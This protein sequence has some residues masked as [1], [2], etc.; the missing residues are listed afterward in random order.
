MKLLSALCALV[1]LTGQAVAGEPVWRIAT[2][3]SYR[4]LSQLDDRDTAEWMRDFDQYILSVSDLLRMDVRQLPP[5]TVIVF[6]R[7]KDYTPYKLM[8]PNGTT[9]NVG[10]QFVWH[11]TWSMI[12]MAYDAQDDQSRRAI[13]HE[14]TH[15][16]MSI[17][18]SAQP[19]W[20]SEGIAEL[21]STFE[22]HGDKVAW[23][24]PIAE[25]LT[26]LRDSGLMPLETFL[27]QPSA[28]FDRDDHTDE[29]YA[30]A[31]AF[32]HF[33][34]FSDNYSRRPLMIKFLQTYRTESGEAT[35]KAV[36]GQSLPDTEHAF[37]VYVN[38]RRWTYVTQPVKVAADPP[39]LQSAPP[40][41]V[42]A[43][44]GFLALGAG[45]PEL[46][47]QHADKSVELDGAAP[48]SHALLAYLAQ[49]GSHTELAA[50]EADAALQ[51]G[52]RDSGLYTLLGDSYVEGTNS[53][54]PD[55]QRTRVSMYEN[56]INLSPWRVDA[57]DRLSEALLSLETP[58]LEDAKF[59]GVGIRAFPGDDWLRVGNAV[60]TERLGQRA[61]AMQAIEAVLRPD[62]KLDPQQREFASNLRARW[63]VADLNSELAEATDKHDFTGARAI[64][65]R[66][67]DRIGTNAQL[68]SFFKD[69][70]A[71][72]TQNEL[73]A[74][75]ESLIH[76]KKKTEARAVA[77]QLLAIP[78]LP[79]P[80]RRYVEQ[81]LA[82]GGRGSSTGD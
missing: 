23:G 64:L 80:M 75:Y 57:Y 37:H 82:A 74:R 66:Y 27:V 63:L 48:E 60:V 77:Q 42:Q 78:D 19:A 24:K 34:M 72:L 22:R 46:A 8:R 65:A 59:L 30:Q 14:A 25:H 62:S 4:I 32:T 71:R 31:W 26:T 16:L 56:A 39:P 33:L 79:A 76:D 43:S 44:L 7:D 52:S 53:L 17:D 9:A 6:A 36:F 11:Q 50:T 21:F 70:D 1:L 45:R 2:T 15:W 73:L 69:S 12:A 55:A 38:E 13:H 41:I 49:D 5:L 81:Q 61:E 3:P 51:R 29:F 35:V 18:Q 54:K 47:K 67:R 28:L 68:E 20:F 40:A 58:R 10:G